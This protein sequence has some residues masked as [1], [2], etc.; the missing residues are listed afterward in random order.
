MINFPTFRRTGRVD[1]PESSTT[2]RRPE[3]ATDAVADK[4][5]SSDR[6]FRYDRRRNRSQNRLMDRRTGVDRR[7]RSLIDFKV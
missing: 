7:R 2:P 1:L 6:R 5:A 3:A 4:E